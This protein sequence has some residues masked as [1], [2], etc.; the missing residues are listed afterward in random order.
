MAKRTYALMLLMG[1]LAVSAVMAQDSNDPPGGND[2]IPEKA[3]QDLLDDNG[4]IITPDDRL[5]KIA[6]DV[7]GGFGG[8]YFDDN[9]A[10][11]VYVY[12]KDTSKTQAAR[13][14]A[15]SV[16]AGDGSISRVT[17]VQ[18]QY[19]FDDLLAWYRSLLNAMA[20]DEIDFSSGA[21]V[22][23]KNRIVIGLPNMNQLDD[24]HT[25]MSDLQI[26]T[27][28]V[29]FEEEEI[30]S[31]AGKDSVTAKWRPV[32]G[33]VQHQITTLGQRCTIGFV[34]ERSDVKGLV[35]ASHCTNDDRIV[36]QEDDSDFH[37]PNKP[38][39]GSNKVAEETIDP[40]LFLN[41][42]VLYYE[43]RWS[44]S[45]FATLD[46]DDDIDRGKI[47]KPTDINETDVDPAGSTF[48]ITSDSGSFSRGTDIYYIGR[49]E[50]L[51]SARITD[52]CV[53][54]IT[55][56]R[57]GLE[58][59]VMIRCA[60]GATMTNGSEGP[61]RGDSGAPVVIH[62]SGNNVKLIGTMFAGS[63]SRFMFSRLGLIYYEL[64]SSSSWDSCVSGC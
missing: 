61:S 26:P 44:D 8:Y 48:S 62:T 51:Q 10:S 47:A 41:G 12:M 15:D 59:G 39:F 46:S 57:R 64:G 13:D 28:A 24:I 60:G 53:D 63:T 45:A 56:L 42:C 43:C 36:G 31:L 20:T 22:E 25:L 23:A 29:V 52:T 54:T 19:A 17:V 33:G 40:P 16:P 3:V 6:E 32:V 9:D 5:A 34:T 30:S 1:A 7:E 38:V 4:R 50:G 49:V 14:A 11:H 55:K 37:Q 27:G 35:L 21:V 58:W 2:S 18:G